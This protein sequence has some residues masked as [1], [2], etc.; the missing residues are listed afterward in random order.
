MESG[1]SF[2]GSNL[3]QSI[4]NAS[5]KVSTQFMSLEPERENPSRKK[6]LEEG[7]RMGGYEVNIRKP[8]I[9][10]TDIR[11]PMAKHSEFWIG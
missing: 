2:V 5:G 7:L 6:A 9:N 3:Y 11:Q 4:A 8:V 1:K 10:R